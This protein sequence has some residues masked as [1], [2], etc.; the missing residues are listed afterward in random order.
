MD[1]IIG[2]LITALIVVLIYIIHKWNNQ[3]ELEIQPHYYYDNTQRQPHYINV[4]RG[5]ESYGSQGSYNAHIPHY[6]EEERCSSENKAAQIAHSEVGVTHLLTNE[7]KLYRNNT[8]THAEVILT[9]KTQAHNITKIWIKN[10]PCAGCSRVLINFFQHCRKPI[11]YVG[12]I[13][14]P[15]DQEDRKGLNNL[16]QQGFELEVWETLHTMKHGPY[17]RITHN[18][19]RDVKEEARDT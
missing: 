15:N 16:C 13:Y 19:L 3:N 12:H 4:N 9:K 8:Y 10:S 11:I 14:R 18:Y 1:V 5:V 2:V 17:S 7:G 6:R